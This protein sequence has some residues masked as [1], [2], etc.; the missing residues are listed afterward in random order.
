MVEARIGLKAEY[1]AAATPEARA[2]AAAVQAILA[3]ERV[4]TCVTVRLR[5]AALERGKRAVS[6]DDRPT[7]LV[8]AKA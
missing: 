2:V 3:A 7:F 1:W 6:R 8:T 4:E 5:V